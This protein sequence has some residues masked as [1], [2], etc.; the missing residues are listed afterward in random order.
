MPRGKKV[1][2][3]Q[4]VAKLRDGLADLATTGTTKLPIEFMAP[5]LE[6]AIGNDF[7]ISRGIDSW[8]QS[9]QL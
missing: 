9:A 2:S 6:P 7:V 3:K 1:S 8:G 4:I 5:Q